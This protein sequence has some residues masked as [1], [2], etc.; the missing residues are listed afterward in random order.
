MRN[1]SDQSKRYYKMIMLL[2]VSVGIE[3]DMSFQYNSSEQ[4]F[5]P[6]NRFWWK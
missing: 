4:I 3:P 5:G 6:L 1:I 2:C